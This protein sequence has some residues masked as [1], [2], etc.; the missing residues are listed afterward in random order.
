MSILLREALFT[1]AAE[2]GEVH[3][4]AWQETY[5]GLLPRSLVQRQT[6][7]SRATAWA[8]LLADATQS[9][10]RV[11]VAQ[12]GPRKVGFGSGGPQRSEAL[13]AQGYDAEIEAIYV[14]AQFQGG[15]IGHSI[16]RWMARRLL[17]DGHHGVSLWVLRDNARARTFYERLGGVEVADREEV[18]PEATLFE[19]AYGW[20]DLRS[21]A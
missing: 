8:R 21:L 7:E 20:S 11:V 17:A 1:D 12:V 13:S 15:G 16:M 9:R 18:R 14:R 19:V 4:L 2:I 6:V 3:A 10:L 5:E